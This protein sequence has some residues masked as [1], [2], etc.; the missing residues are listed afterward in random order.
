LL[1]EKRKEQRSVRFF[2]GMR[3]PGLRQPLPSRNVDDVVAVLLIARAETFT[4]TKTYPPDFF[5]YF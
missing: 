3:S 2:M 5:F 1:Q 4:L